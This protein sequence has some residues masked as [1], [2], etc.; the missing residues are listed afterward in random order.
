MSA[1][2]GADERRVP[3]EATMVP[4]LAQARIINAAA[5]SDGAIPPPSAWAAML[6]APDVPPTNVPR[7]CAT[8]LGTGVIRERIQAPT[9]ATSS[10]VLRAF[11]TGGWAVP[12]D[13]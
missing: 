13:M 1:T 7:S 6:T 9:T 11:P 5:L 3:M 10:R 12:A 4:T 2:A 8:S